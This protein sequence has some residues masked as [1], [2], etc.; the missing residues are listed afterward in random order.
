[1]F[2]KHKECFFSNDPLHICI[3]HM[4]WAP[5]FLKLLFWHLRF[6]L[7]VDGLFWLSQKIRI[8]LLRIYNF[9]VYSHY[10]VRGEGYK[11]TYNHVWS[12][13]HLTCAKMVQL[14]TF[15]CHSFLNILNNLI[16]THS[17]P[18]LLKSSL[19][20][21]WRIVREFGRGKCRNGFFYTTVT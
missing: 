8:K 19:G 10:K 14:Y 7:S 1:M 18:F 9:I 13:F 6:I 11:Y 16:F 2:C 17:S 20:S 12:M 5:Y 3:K 15:Q 21:L 4:L